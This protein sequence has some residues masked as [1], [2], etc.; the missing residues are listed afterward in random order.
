MPWHAARDGMDSEPHGH[1]TL[2][3]RVVKFA[4]FVLGLGNSHSVAGYHN[5]VISCSQNCCGFLCGCAVTAFASVPAAAEVCT[6]PKAPNRTFVNERFIAFDMITERMNPEEPSSAPA[7][8]SSL[9]SSTNPIAAA[10]R[11]AYELS[12]EMT[13]GMSAPPI[14]TTM[15]TPNSIGMPII[16]GN[17]CRPSGC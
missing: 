1:P 17:N 13:V 7:M 11:P 14:G 4:N 16:N 8:M 15:R 9:L 12:R 5:H 2:S 3:Q 10:E 6:C